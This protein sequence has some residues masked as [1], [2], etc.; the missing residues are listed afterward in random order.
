MRR[1]SKL[2]MF[3]ALGGSLGSL[4]PLCAALLFFSNQSQRLV[5]LCGRGL[6]GCASPESLGS[7][8]SIAA[9]ALVAGT[10]G[11]FCLAYAIGRR[12]T[13]PAQLS[14]TPAQ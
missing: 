2:F 1:F 8:F 7:L 12:I 13:S 5:A 14:G 4:L 9:T 11:S 10:I 6:P 3:T